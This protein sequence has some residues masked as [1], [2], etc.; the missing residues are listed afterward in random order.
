MSSTAHGSALLAGAS[1]AGRGGAAVFGVLLCR[2]L[3]SQSQTAT[4]LR[5]QRIA[6]R[7]TLLFQNVP[8]CAQGLW[9]AGKVW[10]AGGGVGG[11]AAVRG[12]DSG[13]PPPPGAASLAYRKGHAGCPQREALLKSSPTPGDGRSCVSYL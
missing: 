9:Q 11:A 1:W 13:P 7:P 12:A 4:G 5:P 2:H 6:S 3:R 10:G 8:P